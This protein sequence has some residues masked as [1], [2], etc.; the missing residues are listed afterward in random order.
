VGTGN[1]N[2]TLFDNPASDGVPGQPCG[3]DVGCGGC[4]PPKNTHGIL[5]TRGTSERRDVQLLQNAPNP[6]CDATEITFFITDATPVRLTVYDVTGRRLKDIVEA[7]LATGQY[8]VVWDATDE[9]GARVP[10]GIYFY[11][12]EINGYRETRRLVIQR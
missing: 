4:I 1:P 12:L 6:F 11:Q 9:Q 2:G 7:Q 3:T 5:L 8:V 10:S